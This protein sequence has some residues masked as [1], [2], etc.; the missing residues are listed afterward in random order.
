MIISMIY[1]YTKNTFT[2]HEYIHNLFIY[3][4]YIS[5]KISI[6]PEKLQENIL[7]SLR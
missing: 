1:K 5:Q 2:Y 4:K 6:I 7:K 3:Y